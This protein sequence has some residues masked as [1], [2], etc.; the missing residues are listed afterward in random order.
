MYGTIAKFQLQPGAEAQLAALEEEYRQVQIPGMVSEYLY[1]LDAKPNTYYMVAVF[2][3][4]DAYFANAESPEQHQ[5]Y[6]KFR[7]ITV[8]DPEWN[9]GEIVEHI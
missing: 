7:A 4:K 9:D 5:R 2:D 1:K 3:S 8:G 6:L